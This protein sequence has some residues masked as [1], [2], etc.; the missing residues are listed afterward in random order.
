MARGTKIGDLL[1]EVS[2]LPQA[3]LKRLPLAREL[4]EG[5]RIE[6]R[7]T[8]KIK[9]YASGAGV[10]EGWVVLDEGATG[11]DFLAKVALSEGA[12]TTKIRRRKR[13]KDGER[14]EIPLRKGRA[15]GKNVAQYAPLRGSSPFSIV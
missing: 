4:Q 5:Q 6:F 11:A 10:R 13:L 14:I 7:L 8:Q 1:P 3:D 15:Q 12:L 2:P 9:V